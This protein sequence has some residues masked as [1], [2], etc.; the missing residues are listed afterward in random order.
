MNQFFQKV[1]KHWL[2]LLLWLA[3][4]ILG[5]CGFFIAND[6]NIRIDKIESRQ[7]IVNGSWNISIQWNNNPMIQGEIKESQI[8][9]NSSI[10]QTVIPKTLEEKRIEEISSR[11]K[12]ILVDYYNA[13]NNKDFKRIKNLQD[14]TFIWDT[15]LS[16]YFWPEH[17]SI[18]LKSLDWTWKIQNIE[19]DLDKRK[20]TEFVSRRWFNYEMYYTLKNWQVFRDKWNAIVK[21]DIENNIYLVN[22]ISCETKRCINQPF[23][24]IK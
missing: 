13:I 10:Q 11:S 12:S 2:A 15:G 23:F 14:N 4:N 19:E 20:D 24:S 3:A 7:L 8:Y 9:Q 6:A 16:K 17:L 22:A 1:S 5:V 18:F 21:Y